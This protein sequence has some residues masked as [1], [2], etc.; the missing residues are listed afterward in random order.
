MNDGFIDFKSEILSGP[1]RLSMRVE[2]VAS[3]FELE[4]FDNDVELFREAMNSRL[5]LNYTMLGRYLEDELPI[6][7]LPEFVEI[8][9]Y[10][11]DADERVA[12]RRALTDLDSI[13]S[14]EF[15]KGEISLRPWISFI[16]DDEIVSYTQDCYLESRTP[17]AVYV[18]DW[19]DWTYYSI[20]SDDDIPKIDGNRNY[21]LQF[22]THFMIDRSAHRPWP[23]DTISEVIVRYLQDFLGNREDDGM[24]DYMSEEAVICAVEDI[25]HDLRQVLMPEHF[26]HPR[27][28]SV[29]SEKPTCLILSIYETPDTTYPPP[30]WR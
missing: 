19:V 10:L 1:I 25:A 14:H 30:H 18:F 4:P 26:E 11:R 6:G 16:E 12:V 21:L 9:K 28:C 2:D 17:L 20:R 13:L 15:L 5:N 24:P 7:E 29:V 22:I 3:L 8:A 23:L 27:L